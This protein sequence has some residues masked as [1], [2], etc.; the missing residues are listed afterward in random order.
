MYGYIAWTEMEGLVRMFGSVKLL[1]PPVKLCCANGLDRVRTPPPAFGPAE[2]EPAGKGG[3]AE[4]LAPNIEAGQYTTDCPAGTGNGGT[5]IIY[6]NVPLRTI[7]TLAKV[8][9]AV[10]GAVISM[11]SPAL[12]V[13]ELPEKVATPPVVKAMLPMDEPFFRR[14]NETAPVGLA[15]HTA[16]LGENWEANTTFRSSSM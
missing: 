1:H 9:S 13:T 5:G 12:N 11:M 10:A 14:F 8:V 4:L 3:L 2:A 6:P 15:W 16:V 7:P